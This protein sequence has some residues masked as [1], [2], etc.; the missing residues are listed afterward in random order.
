[1]K[2]IIVAVDFSAVSETAAF[3]AADLALDIQA[4]LVLFH[5]YQYPFTTGEVPLPPQVFQGIVDSARTAIES[6]SKK[7]S[8][9]LNGKC[10]VHTEL[11]EGSLVSRLL[12]YC[13]E[14]QP[15]FI[16]MGSTGISAG[17]RFFL[18]SQALSAIKRVP[19]PV[20]IIPPKTSYNGIKA[21]GLATDL[22]EVA[23]TLPVPAIREMIKSFHA[24][25]HVMFVAAWYEYDPGR[26][27]EVAKIE[28]L[29][30]KEGAVVHIVNDAHFEKGI[31]RCCTEYKI[32][33][34]MIV[35]H[36][37]SFF[38]KLLHQTHTAQL[39]TNPMLPMLFMKKEE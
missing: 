32:D 12:D 18:G 15:G 6:L 33:I 17:G 10:G 35:P 28:S 19:V 30:G 27:K 20:M 29:F 38:E 37:H 39:L 25:L 22:H 16:V 11:F 34:L 31:E 13:K 14:H 3:Y 8:A 2:T 1:M 9:R 21:V 7:L 4:D 5:A 26:S 24:K 36:K 23:T